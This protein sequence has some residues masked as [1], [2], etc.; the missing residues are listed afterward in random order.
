MNR[1][2]AMVISQNC[3]H[4]LLLPLTTFP[5]E[6]LPDV[7]PEL[8]PEPPPTFEEYDPWLPPSLTALSK[9]LLSLLEYPPL[10]LV[11]L[12][13]PVPV[14]N[15]VLPPSDVL[16]DLPITPVSKAL[17]DPPTTLLPP[18]LPPPMLNPPAL[19]LLKPFPAPSLP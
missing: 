15:P 8:L 2:V 5:P 19:R 12:A 17:P 13:D 4:W 18:P 10:L 11:E 1:V 9:P 16:L 7:L 6:L 3:Y 14:E